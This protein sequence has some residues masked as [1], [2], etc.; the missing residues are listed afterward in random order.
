VS[1]EANPGDILGQLVAFRLAGVMR[2]S[3]GVQSLRDS[4]LVFFNRDHTVAQALA[5]IEE[6][7]RVYSDS[8]SVDVL[9]GRPGQVEVVAWL[10]ELDRLVGL[11]ANH[12]SLFQLTAEPGTKLHKLV[13]NGQ[14]FSR[15]VTTKKMSA[16]T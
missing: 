10:E 4:D 7:G 1:L 15:N 2:L 3:L 13:T 11:G 8:F 5:A 12:I 6:C 9:F 14:E 16:F